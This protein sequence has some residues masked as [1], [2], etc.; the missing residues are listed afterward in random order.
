MFQNVIFQMHKKLL[1]NSFLLHLIDSEAIKV[2][3]NYS[4]RAIP[5]LIY[6]KEAIVKYSYFYRK[7]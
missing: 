1:I 2:N 3:F 4:Q 6:A 7:L 5:Y